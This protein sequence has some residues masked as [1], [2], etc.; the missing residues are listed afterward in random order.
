MLRKTLTAALGTM[1]SVALLT[2]G[3]AT[4]AGA[5]TPSPSSAASGAGAA[6]SY[7]WYDD[8]SSYY[9]CCYTTS[10]YASMD[11]CSHLWYEAWSGATPSG[12]AS[13]GRT[14]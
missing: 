10:Y 3:T 14:D 11:L 13:P 4:P 9:S 5:R 1:M 6:G 2:A 8:C 12:P 7:S